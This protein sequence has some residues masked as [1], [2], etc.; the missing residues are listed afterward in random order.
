[1]NSAR[2]VIRWSIPGTFFLLSLV[3]GQLVAVIGLDHQPDLGVELER[4]NAALV[5]V[6]LAASIPIG[7]FIY[8]TY[9]SLLEEAIGWLPP[10]VVPID[11]GRHILRRLSPAQ[12]LRIRTESGIADIDASPLPRRLRP[13][14]IRAELKLGSGRQVPDH[15]ADASPRQIYAYLRHQNWR[16]IK[17]ALFNDL[18][19]GRSAVIRKEYADFSDIYHSIGTC[20]LATVMGFVGLLVYDI[21]VHLHPIMRH[22]V[23]A[24]F[25][26]GAWFFVVYVVFIV[27]TVAR[28][29]TLNSIQDLVADNLRRYIEPMSDAGL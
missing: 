6:L 18:D 1:V 11:R 19:E 14:R 15:L 7:F 2:Q 9:H 29:H 27:L 4:S 13:W 22:W 17:W 10:F 5:A 26:F 12:R 16:A 28:R 25:V 20:R 23:R 21:S 3:F 24:A 8:Q